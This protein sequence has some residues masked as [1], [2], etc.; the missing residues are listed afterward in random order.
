MTIADTSAWVELLRD[1]PSPA[2]SRLSDL[3]ASELVAIVD[4]IAMELLAGARTK[5]E[6]RAIQRIILGVHLLRVRG[7]GPWEEAA[8]IYRACRR[9]GSTVR[10]HLDCLIA[11]VAIREDVPVLHA[12]RDFDLIAQHTP[13]RVAAAT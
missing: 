6:E 1:R 2:A 3:V 4:P 7:F 10:S 9:A 5:D 8:S 13:L 12:D 11:A